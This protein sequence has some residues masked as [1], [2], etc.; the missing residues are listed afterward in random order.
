ML[1]DEQVVNCL[2]AEAS[3]NLGMLLLCFRADMMEINLDCVATATE[4]A[5]VL[6][7][8]HA[9]PVYSFSST[10]AFWRVFDQWIATTTSR[11]SRI[12]RR[13]HPTWGWPERDLGG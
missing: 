4:L 12:A 13:A 9:I 3:T 8:L 6:D 2:R 1:T 11:W 5:A 10:G 7:A